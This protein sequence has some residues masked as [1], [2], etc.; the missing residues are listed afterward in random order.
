[1]A[2][3]YHN[4]SVRLAKFLVAL[5]AVLSELCL[6]LSNSAPHAVRH[7]REWPAP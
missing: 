7:W 5:K 4:A 1:M 2:T 3:E 6:G